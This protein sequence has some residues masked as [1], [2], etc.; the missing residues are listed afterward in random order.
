MKQQLT[1]TEKEHYALKTKRAT[2][3]EQFSKNPVNTRLALAIKVIDD[4]LAERIER[5]RK[6][7]SNK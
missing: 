6:P 7:I 1:D 2:L 5:M 3:F 4:Q